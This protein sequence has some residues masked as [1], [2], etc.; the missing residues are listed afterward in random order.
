MEYL[1]QSFQK[2]RVQTVRQTDRQTDAHD[3]THYHAAFAG[4]NNNEIL[5]NC[6][7]TYN[8]QTRVEIHVCDTLAKHTKWDLTPLILL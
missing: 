8:D 6:N 4:G 3:R 1:D 5:I 7:P 2:L